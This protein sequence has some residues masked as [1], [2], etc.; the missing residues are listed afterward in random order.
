MPG[1]IGERTLIEPEVGQPDGDVSGAAVLR[2]VARRLIPFL[3]LLYIVNIV[4]R[5]NV[6]FAK[7]R[8]LQDL[9]LNETVYGLGAGMFY[10]GY[11]LFEVPSNL[12]LHRVGARRWISRIMVTWGIISACLMFVRDAK[13]LLPAA[14]PARDRRGRL[15][16]RHHPVP[17]LLVPRAERR[18]PWRGS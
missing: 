15:L 5:M 11:M 1:E 12:I 16:P 4:D 13:E 2:K 6:G 7:L 8:M 3:F 14:D 9:G 18:G 10:V 17:E